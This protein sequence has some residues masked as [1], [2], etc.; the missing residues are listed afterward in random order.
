MANKYELEEA[1]RQLMNHISFFHKPENKS[2]EMLAEYSSDAKWI[3]AYPKNPS[4]ITQIS[5]NNNV[6]LMGREIPRGLVE[7]LFV[8]GAKCIEFAIGP[9]KYRVF[10]KQSKKSLAMDAE[11]PYDY[12]ITYCVQ[13]GVNEVWKNGKIITPAEQIE[14]LDEAFKKLRELVDL[15]YPGNRMNLSTPFIN[16]TL[17]SIS[18]GIAYIDLEYLPTSGTGWDEARLEHILFKQKEDTKRDRA[19]VLGIHGGVEAH[20]SID[21]FSYSLQMDLRKKTHSA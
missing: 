8:K 11:I 3:E 15:Y 4:C 17:N 7:V 9:T 18:R 2:L 20:I 13:G 16:L 6:I 19:L 5:F 1:R 14:V 10:D 21:K 12:Y